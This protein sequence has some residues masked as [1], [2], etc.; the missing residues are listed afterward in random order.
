MPLRHGVKTYS[1]VWTSYWWEC[2]N[3]KDKTCSSSS[4]MHSI[5][6]H[7]ENK[8]AYPCRGR[9]HLHRGKWKITL[10]WIVVVIL[11]FYLQID[12]KS[13]RCD[14]SCVVSFKL[15]EMS[16]IAVFHNTEILTCPL[17][18]LHLMSC[19]IV[20]TRNFFLCFHAMVNIQTEYGMYDNEYILNL[21]QRGWT[22][23]TSLSFMSSCSEYTLSVVV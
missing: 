12:G 6:F 3:N 17:F 13:Y 11:L 2:A 4:V 5:I 14:F 22:G 8:C 15:S 18:D 20:L 10:K 9:I 16:P 1:I 19:W 21:R 23:N 7:F